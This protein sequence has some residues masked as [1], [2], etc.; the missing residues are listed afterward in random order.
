[1]KKTP[2]KPLL[3]SL[4]ACVALSVVSLSPA[5]AQDSDFD[6]LQKA[7]AAGDPQS[8]FKLGQAYDNGVGVKQDQ[9]KAAGRPAGQPPCPE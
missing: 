7:A 4:S 9:A 8:E 1:M 2:F 6:H 3:L 5:R